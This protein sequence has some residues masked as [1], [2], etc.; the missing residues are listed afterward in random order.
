MSDTPPTAPTAAML[1]IGDEILSGR[2]QD[3]NAHHLANRLSELGIRLVE[4]RTV[5][6]RHE[7]IRDTVRDLSARVDTL[8]TSG[9]IGPTH[10]DITADAVAEAFGAAIDIRQDARALLVER[11]GEDGLNAARLRMARIPDGAALVDNPVSAAPG[12]RIGNA[13][14]LAGVPEIFR[15][16]LDGIEPSLKGGPPIRSHAFEVAV[17]EGDAAAALGDLQARHPAVAI[18][19]YPLYR[20]RPMARVVLRSS[21]RAALATAAADT[22]A[23]LAG[24]VGP[25]DI[26]EQP[27]G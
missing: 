2:I 18:G 27:P 11:Y 19:C 26:T 23:A 25:A 6:D 16:M 14:V 24:L 20:G 5:P 7:T 1:V 21:D 4:I 3:L 13:Y 12:F 22:R 15:A 17:A 8:F 10:D 9:G